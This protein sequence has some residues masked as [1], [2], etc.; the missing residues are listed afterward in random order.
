MTDRELKPEQEAREEIDALLQSAGWEI[1]DFS[2][3]D[4]TSTTGV[5]VRE[6]PVE[7][8][9]ADYLLFVDGQAVGVIEAKPVGTTL[10]GVEAQSQKYIEGFP[11]GYDCVEDPLPFAY[12]S[13]GTQTFVR[14]TRE[15]DPKP[16]RVFAFHQPETLSR[17]LRKGSLKSR[18]NQLPEL[19]QGRLRDCQYEAIQGLESSL[20]RGDQRA[21]VQMATGSG[22]TYMA[23]M[24]A[25]RLIKHADTDRILFLVDRKSLGRQT[26]KEFQQFP[27]PGDGRK[28][29]ELWSP[30]VDSKV[31]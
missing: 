19:E 12:E 20:K 8:G 11:E 28:F 31:H 18:L 15:E 5:A 2:D 17:W 22:K 14:D 7:T 26:K 30:Q 25:Y 9:D 3:I 29:T 23:A 13:T 21:L 10:S 16:R 4:V 1:Q 24:Q 6:F 27:V